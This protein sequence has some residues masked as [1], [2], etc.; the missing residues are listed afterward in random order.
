MNFKT[1]MEALKEGKRVKRTSWIEEGL[2][3]FMHVT[4]EIKK[5]IVFRMQSIPQSVKDEFQRRFNDVSQQIDA[6]YYD[7]PL[8]IVNS[9]NVISTWTPSFTDT[10]FE[11]WIVLD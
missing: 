5:E 8:A 6:I 11:D 2:F 4:A 7:N 3:D 10:Q 1:A 9:S